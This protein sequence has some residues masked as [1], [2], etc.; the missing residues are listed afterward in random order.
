M[1]AI[2]SPVLWEPAETAC[3]LLAA[4]PVWNAAR[5]L[6]SRWEDGLDL[7]AVSDH[8]SAPVR[9]ARV[10]VCVTVGVRSSWSAVVQH[11]CAGP[12]MAG[13]VP[14]AQVRFRQAHLQ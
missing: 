7:W 6:G 9:V 2:R 8:R 4:F 3:Q 1:D 11:L 13:D 10:P 12:A 14:L 5:P